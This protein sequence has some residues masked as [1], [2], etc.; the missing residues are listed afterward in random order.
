[1]SEKQKLKNSRKCIAKEAN[2]RNISDLLKE[3]GSGNKQAAEELLLRFKPLILSTIK[4]HYTGTDWEDMLQ[5]ATLSFLEGIKEY[6]AEKGIPFPA[7]IKT[8]LNF[9][10][11]NICRK[12]RNIIF[13]QLVISNE[14]QNLLERLEDE[15]VDIQQ[16]YLRKEESAALHKALNKL[17]PKQRKVIVL[18]FFENLTLKEIAKEMNI[19][20]KTAQRYKAKG[21]TKLADLLC[22]R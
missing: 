3:A 11:Y 14:E 10:I 16:D 8:K 20:Y 6:D 9:D 7:Y 17:H 2:N 5:S 19:S 4:R 1:M 22:F 13:Y 18:H 21:M 15:T 12:N